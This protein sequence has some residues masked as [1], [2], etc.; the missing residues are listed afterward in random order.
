MVLLVGLRHKMVVQKMMEEVMGIKLLKLGSPNCLPAT[1][2]S[3]SS[4]RQE[5]RAEYKLGSP[6]YFRH[7]TDLLDLACLEKLRICFLFRQDTQS[8]SNKL[9]I[10]FTVTQYVETLNVR[11]YIMIDIQKKR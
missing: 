8:S 10:L 4:N 6:V 7:C 5:D 11:Q 2:T 3:L 9:L 1:E